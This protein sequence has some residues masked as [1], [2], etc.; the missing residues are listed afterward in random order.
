MVPNQENKEAIAQ[1][2]YCFWRKN[3]SLH[4]R[5]ERE[6]CYGE[7]TSSYLST[8][9]AVFFAEHD[10]GDVKSQVVL[11][12][13]CLAFWCI[14]AISLSVSQR[15]FITIWRTFSITTLFLLPD[16]RDVSMVED[17]KAP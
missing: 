1:V 11:F 17:H 7:A 13:N 3:L 10:E 2:P 14:F 5:N 12:I 6:H 15:S 8:C 16:P 9:M 4:V